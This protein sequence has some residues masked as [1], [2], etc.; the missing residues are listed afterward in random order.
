[1]WNRRRRESEWEGSGGEEGGIA[2]MGYKVN[3]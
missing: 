2:M 1:M 3:K